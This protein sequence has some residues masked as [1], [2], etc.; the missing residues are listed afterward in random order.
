MIFI[1]FDIIV[2]KADEVNPKTWVAIDGLGRELAT[3]RS[4]SSSHSRTVGIFYWTWHS[5]IADSAPININDFYKKYPDKKNDYNFW[6][7]NKPAEF[8]SKNLSRW[9]YWNE[10]IF[11]YYVESDDYIY[12]KHAELLADAEVDFVVFDCTNGSVY[13]GA[14]EGLLELS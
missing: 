3:D 14:V 1:M 4:K 13:R 8:K 6:Q 12:R 7:N 9:P 11:G 5:K 2:V 10:S